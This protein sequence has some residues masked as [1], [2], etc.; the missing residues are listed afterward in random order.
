MIISAKIVRARKT[1]T[2]VECGLSI[3]AGAE[4]LRL[5]GAADEYDKPYAVRTHPECCR[6]RHPKI[7][8]AKGTL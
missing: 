6:Y 3:Q 8:R 2:C 7:L 4:C 5:F 1:H